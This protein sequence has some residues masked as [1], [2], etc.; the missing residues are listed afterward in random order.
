[1]PATPVLAM[2][3]RREGEDQNPLVRPTTDTDR[4][5]DTYTVPEQDLGAA[6]NRAV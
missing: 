1:M 5:R 4:D 6:R 2:S 3:E